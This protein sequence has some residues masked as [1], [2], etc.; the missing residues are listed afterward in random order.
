MST[1]A[2]RSAA[3]PA[4]GSRPEQSPGAANP[5]SVPPK[6]GRPDNILDTFDYA[7]SHDFRSPLRSM[8]E[9]A[10]LM[11]EDYAPHVPN[12]IRLFLSD[13]VK[14]SE[15]LNKR[16]EGLLRYS[17]LNRQP[18]QCGEVNIAALVKEVLLEGGEQ[19]EVSVRELPD[20]AGDP[21]MIRQVFVEL[22]TNAMKFVRRGERPRIEIGAQSQISRNEYF[23]ADQGVGFDMKYA[24]KLFGLFQRL[25][26]E[27]EFEGIGVGLTLARCIVER[28]GGAMRAEASKG[29]GATFY[30][31]L[32]AVNACAHSDH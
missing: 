9:M 1:A 16:A 2:K 22:L 19:A 31:T 21:V 12:D 7:I 18:L 6:S 25:H 20:A 8:E 3:N 32:P 23:V 4:N 15:K 17:R 11:L 10:R 5:V 29:Q 13:V 14:T 26:K 24:T 30:F 28:H 27:T